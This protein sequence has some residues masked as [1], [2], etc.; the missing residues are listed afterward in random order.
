M[1]SPKDLQVE[2]L[3]TNLKKSPNISVEGFLLLLPV[4]LRLISELSFFLDRLSF[5]F[6]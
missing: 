5:R 3:K 2:L 1:I 4:G 6:L